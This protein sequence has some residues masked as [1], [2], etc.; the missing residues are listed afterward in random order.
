MAF[1]GS[2][3]WPYDGQRPRSIWCLWLQNGTWLKAGETGRARTAQKTKQKRFR[4]V[5]GL[6]ARCYG[7]KRETICGSTVEC[8]TRL[9]GGHFE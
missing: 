3:Q 9:A 5:V 1:D 7:I 8:L 2:S 4:N 6:M